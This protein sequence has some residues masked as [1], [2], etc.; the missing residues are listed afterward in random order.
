[1]CSGVYGDCPEYLAAVGKSTDDRVPWSAAPP[2]PP[3]VAY[4]SAMAYSVAGTY[5]YS[6]MRTVGKWADVRVV[7][8]KVGD[9]G[10]S[11]A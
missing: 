10:C 9:Y 8:V 3:Y 7:K 2:W 6:V 1:M 11:V 5:C 4:E